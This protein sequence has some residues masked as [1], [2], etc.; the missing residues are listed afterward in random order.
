MA[1]DN[2]TGSMTAVGPTE[3]IT[4]RGAEMSVSGTFVASWV[5]EVRYQS[6]QIHTLDA[7]TAPAT[8]QIA[9]KGAPKDVRLRI[10]DYTSG[11]IRYDIDGMPR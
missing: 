6:G 1:G 4:L 2:I 10:T 8:S 3:W 5:F 7:G 11:T 9:F